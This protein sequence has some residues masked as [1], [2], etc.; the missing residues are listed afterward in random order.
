MQYWFYYSIYF[1][2]SFPTH[3][4]GQMEMFCTTVVPVSKG[5]LGG[6]SPYIFLHDSSGR[7][8]REIVTLLFSNERGFSMES[9]L[10]RISSNSLLQKRNDSSVVL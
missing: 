6:D 7:A 3:H 2:F 1:L 10:Q 5:H 4:A 9:G 8:V